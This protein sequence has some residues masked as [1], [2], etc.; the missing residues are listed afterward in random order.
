MSFLESLWFVIC[1]KASGV[2]EL[3]SVSL[4]FTCVSLVSHLCLVL[5][6]KGETRILLNLFTNPRKFRRAW[7]AFCWGLPA[8]TELTN[9]AL[10]WVQ[11]RGASGVC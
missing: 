5:L 8:M 4:V 11:K 10:L 2:F 3:G 6:S 9:G 7:Q 1:S